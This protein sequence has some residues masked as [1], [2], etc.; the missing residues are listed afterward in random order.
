MFRRHPVLA[1]ITFV[2]LGVVGWVTLGPQPLD[3]SGNAL[4]FRLLD[5]LDELE[6]RAEHYTGKATSVATDGDATDP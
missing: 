4:L 5:R 1:V 6:L 2:Y 3:S